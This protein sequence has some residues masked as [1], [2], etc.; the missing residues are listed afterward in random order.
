[1]ALPL[2]AICLLNI[3]AQGDIGNLVGYSRITDRPPQSMKDYMVP[4]PHSSMVR[5][6][7]TVS[8]SQILS[9]NMQ[10]LCTSVKER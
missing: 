5:T 4:I 2:F 7:T 10:V 6:A 8:I 9:L 1:M 3:N